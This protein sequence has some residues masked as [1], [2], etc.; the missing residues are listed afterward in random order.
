MI[1]SDHL[2]C[3]TNRSRKKNVQII[4]MKTFFWKIVF[5]IGLWTKQVEKREKWLADHLSLQQSLG[6]FRWSV[7]EGLDRSDRNDVGTAVFWVDISV[8]Y[9]TNAGVRQIV[10]AGTSDI[11]N[12]YIET[13]TC[14][15]Q[16][17][18]FF[19]CTITHNYAQLP[20]G[21]EKT[22]ERAPVDSS[23]DMLGYHTSDCDLAV[24]TAVGPWHK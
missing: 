10:Y 24:S 14:A 2:V 21:A 19:D 8:Q 13:K 7:T 9:C 16:S 23:M 18:R 3:L 6:I 12:E 11:K 22:T 4:W 20:P 5:L 17:I 1:I 15:L